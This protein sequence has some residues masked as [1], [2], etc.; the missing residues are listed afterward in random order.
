MASST[1]TAPI[2]ITSSSWARGSDFIII[3]QTL[4]QVPPRINENKGLSQGP[5]GFWSASRNILGYAGARESVDEG[6]SMLHT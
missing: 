3:S 2:L 6:D 4:N 1:F 5:R